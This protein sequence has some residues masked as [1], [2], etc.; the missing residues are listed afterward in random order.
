[1]KRK[2]YKLIAGIHRDLTGKLYRTG[3]TI[4]VGP[5]EDLVASF[6]GKFALVGTEEARQTPAPEIVDAVFGEQQKQPAES[7]FGSNRTSK[8]EGAAEAG[9]QVYRTEEGF[10]HVVDPDQPDRAL[11]A[12]PLLKARVAACIE[13][14]SKV[15]A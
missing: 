5:A 8:F 3:D 2:T 11:N 14:F 1:M 6:P 7:K 4:T 10:Y 9:L 15:E 12:K 13:K